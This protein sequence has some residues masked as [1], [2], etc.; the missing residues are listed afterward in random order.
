MIT[1]SRTKAAIGNSSA[2]HFPDTLRTRPSLLK[3]LLVAT[4]V[5][6]GAT[7]VAGSV[8]LAAEGDF[9]AEAAVTSLAQ[10]T[11]LLWVIIGASLVIFMQAG[12]ALVETGFCRAKHAAHVVATNFAIFGLGFVGFFFVGFPLA[13]GGFSYSAFGL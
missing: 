4:A 7:F 10:A 6:S 2:D 13:F 3:R 5:S 9:D 12:F 8:A 11:N 1:L